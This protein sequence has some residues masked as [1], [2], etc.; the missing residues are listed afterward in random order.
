MDAAGKV[1]NRAVINHCTVKK[2]KQLVYNRSFWGCLDE[3]HAELRL[4]S[5]S[6]F[7]L[8][9]RDFVQLHMLTTS[10]SSS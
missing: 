10:A 8:F 5:A 2:I 1:K 6:F 4:L 9:G 3:G 7:Q